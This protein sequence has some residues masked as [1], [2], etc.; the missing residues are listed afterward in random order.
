MIILLDVPVSLIAIL[1]VVLFSSIA[2]CGYVLMVKVKGR[3]ST[4]PFL[5]QIMDKKCEP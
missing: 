2:K 4:G 3:V 5:V 1:N